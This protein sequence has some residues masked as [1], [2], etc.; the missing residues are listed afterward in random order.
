VANA[1]AGEHFVSPPRKTPQHR[2][3]FLVVLRLAQD[4][5]VN[6][7]GRVGAEDNRVGRAEALHYF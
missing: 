1:D 3:R 5:T 4:L 6:D 2:R 7:D